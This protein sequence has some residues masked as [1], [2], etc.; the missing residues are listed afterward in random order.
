[1]STLGRAESAALLV[2]DVEC[3][4][5]PRVAGAGPARWPGAAGDGRRAAARPGACGGQA[6]PLGHGPARSQPGPQP[7]RPVHLARPAGVDDAGH[8]WQLVSD[9]PGAGGHVAI[10]YEMIH[11]TRVIPL[12]GAP[13]VGKAP[14]ALT[15]ATRV[16][17]GK[18]TRSSSTRPTSRIRPPIGALT[19][20]HAAAGRALH[21]D[22]TEHGA[23][24]SHRRRSTHVGT[25]LDVCDEPDEEG[26]ESATVSNTRA[27]KGTTGCETS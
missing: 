24:G 17:T 15:W 4:E 20:R 22:R 19:V 1:M 14:F 5:Q 3:E 12:G 23:V 11:E 7:V 25:A 18:G 6:A 27:T 8:L 9:S 26:S 10:R 21:A 2:G 13:H 16:A